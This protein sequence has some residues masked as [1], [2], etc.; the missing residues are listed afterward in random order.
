MRQVHQ[1][2]SK[3]MPKTRKKML[4]SISSKTSL[5]LLLM[6]SHLPPLTSR[7][8]GKTR[9]PHSPFCPVP[10]CCTLYKPKQ[11]EYHIV[12]LP[13]P[14]PHHLPTLHA[15]ARGR[16][17]SSK[18]RT[19]NLNLTS[20]AHQDQQNAPKA[21]ATSKGTYRDSSHHG[22]ACDPPHTAHPS[23]NLPVGHL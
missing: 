12:D 21:T 16:N 4:A 14:P 17:L 18:C 8:L 20:K 3:N 15:W 11:D 23:P 22:Q 13:P 6:P 5:S 1:P 2:F 19:N 7:P 10:A 9:P